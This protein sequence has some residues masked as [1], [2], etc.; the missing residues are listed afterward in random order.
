MALDNV[1]SSLTLIHTFSFL[2]NQFWPSSTFKNQNLILKMQTLKICDLKPK[3]VDSF[4]TCK[5]EML[6]FSNYF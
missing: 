4:L 2:K 3:N 5:T 6:T 1:H